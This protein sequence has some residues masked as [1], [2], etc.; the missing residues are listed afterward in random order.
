MTAKP[1]DLTAERDFELVLVLS[2]GN[3]LGAFEAGVYECLHQ[4]GLEPDWVIGASIGAINAALIAG[5]APEER[6]GAL[7]RFWRR[8]GDEPGL[9]MSQTFWLAGPETARRTAATA[10]TALF[11]RSGIFGPVL[12][13]ALPWTTD[14]PAIFETDQLART[15]DALI[16]FDCL[17]EGPCRFTATAVDLETGDDVIFDSCSQRIDSAHIRASAALP[18]AFPP[19]QIGHKWLVDGGL[20]AN[21]PLDPLFEDPPKRPTLCIAV[22]LLPLT[23][24]RPHTIGEAASRMQDLIFAAQSRRTIARWRTAYEGR[25][26][27]GIALVRVAYQD[28][29]AEIAGK[30][31]DFSDATIAKRWQA[32]YDAGANLSDRI[33][34][35]IIPIGVAGLHV[36]DA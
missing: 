23:G 19:V 8:A 27:T 3:A 14:G 11:G 9:D 22:D 16:D 20:S 2:G 21:L 25:D 36:V 26:R 4:R 1:S 15:L 33:A 35:D 7:R 29:S 12:S 30:A 34:A 18:V 17:N 13:A 6:L 28:Q 32:G 10:W 31:F 24:A 5:S